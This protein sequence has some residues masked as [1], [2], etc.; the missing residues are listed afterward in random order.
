MVTINFLIIQ[1]LLLTVTYHMENIC[2]PT[3]GK[4]YK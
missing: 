2:K 1:A 4:N 3:R